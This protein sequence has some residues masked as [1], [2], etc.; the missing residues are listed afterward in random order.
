M[1]L[2]YDK[3]SQQGMAIQTV[4]D[5]GNNAGLS[6]KLTMFNLSTEGNSK[7]ITNKKTGERMLMQEFLDKNVGIKLD[8]LGEPRSVDKK[9]TFTDWDPANSRA[10]EGMLTIEI[11]EGE[12]AEEWQVKANPNLSYN[13]HLIDEGAARTLVNTMNYKYALPSMMEQNIRTQAKRAGY[14]NHTK[15]DIITLEGQIEIL[16]NAP[17]NTTLEI[18]LKTSRGMI[19]G[20]YVMTKGSDGD[21][22]ITDTKTEKPEEFKSNDPHTQK[23]NIK[24][25]LIEQSGM[26]DV[27]RIYINNKDLYYDDDEARRTNLGYDFDSP[28]FNVDNPQ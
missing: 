22:I 15:D 7:F 9:L 4:L 21:V 27:A 6:D 19:Q 14:D 12:D 10:S 26:F 16:Q 13:Q 5:A 11:G 23:S 8:A 18:P 20:R 25:Y 24:D 2:N 28:I 1:H 17:A 3:D